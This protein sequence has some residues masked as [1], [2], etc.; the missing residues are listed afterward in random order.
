MRL[1]SFFLLSLAASIELQGQPNPLTGRLRQFR[2]QNEPA[3][4]RELIDLL[5]IPNVAAN[6]ADIRRNAEQLRA[7]MTK[8]GIQ[9]QLL[10]LPNAPVSVYGELRS[11]GATRTVVFYAHFD[12]QP[13][14]RTRWVSDPWKPVLRSGPLGPGVRD[15]DPAGDHGRLDPEGRIFARSASDDKSPIVAMLWAL[16]A[17]RA[18]GSAPSVN[19]KF[20]LE[21][22]EEAGSSNL[23]SMLTKYQDLLAADFWIFADGPVHQSRAAQ[24]V[25]GV[26]GVVG[27]N[28]TIYGPSRPLHSGHY[29]NW[30][31]NPNAMMVHLLASM[32]DTEGRI[33]I[34]GFYDDVKSLTEAERAASRAVPAVEGQLIDELRLGRTEGAPATLAEQ[35]ALPALNMSGLS[36]GLGT[37]EGGAN[38]IVPESRAYVDFRLVPNQ[39]PARVRE[40]V[41]GH[42][43][44]VGFHLVTTEP[45]SLTRQSHPRVIRVTWSGGYPAARTSLDHPGARA[46][47][48]A[49]D[50]IRGHPLIRVPTLGGSLPLA[51]FVAVLGIPFAILPIVNHD[52]NQHGENENL[53][54]QN[55]WDGI[56][57]Y[58][59][60]LARMGR[61]WQAVP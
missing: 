38:L 22:E 30:A 26:R 43:R 50:A 8:R 40:L 21:G 34:P 9:V 39:T 56:E 31:P 36:G 48:A 14:D 55:L 28:L 58:A 12:G 16:D 44:R 4:V 20:F 25:F 37:A 18:A 6:L 45:D 11:P 7:M 42:I 52:N 29:G 60:V 3:I 41:E 54:L 27:L 49:A 1:S 19:L 2:E 17:L 15:L 57:L 46:M 59:G 51:D 61:E 5:A 35:L 32:R 53:R 24:A 13:I 33:T 47:L 10:E 23:R